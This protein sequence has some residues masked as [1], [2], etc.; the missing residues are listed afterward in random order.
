MRAALVAF[1]WAWVLTVLVEGVVLWFGLEGRHDRRTRVFAALW[2][3]SCTLPVVHF[4]FPALR[5]AGLS[6]AGWM[7]LAEVFAPLAEC[8]LFA[9]VVAPA[10]ACPESIRLPT[11]CQRDFAAIVV[12]HRA[13]FDLGL[14]TQ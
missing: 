6:D 7:G 14:P 1:A 12:A 2:L 11:W 5:G 8:A 9:L 4:A 10:T 13:S 3:S